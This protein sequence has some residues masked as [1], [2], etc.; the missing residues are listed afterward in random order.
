MARQAWLISVS[1][2]IEMD[3]EDARRFGALWQAED[4][5]KQSLLT[6]LSDRVPNQPL[7]TVEWESLSSTPLDGK[8]HFERCAVCNRWVF[9]VEAPSPA[10]I[11]WGLC[12]GAVVE[13]RFLCDEHLPKDHPA[14]F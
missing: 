12:R 4:A 5:L 6:A 11:P 3:E 13:G 14:A 8:P 2:I 7:T 9:D 1:A 10:Y